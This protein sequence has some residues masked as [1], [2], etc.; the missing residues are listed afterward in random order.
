LAG[1]KF[2][3]GTVF[4]PFGMTAERRQERALIVEYEGLIEELLRGLSP[5]TLALAVKL[6]RLPEH[7][8]GFGVVKESNFKRVRRDWNDLLAQWREGN[9]LQSAS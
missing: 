5:Q 6:A 3:R 9:R 7:I 2:L 1:L 4:D 8:R